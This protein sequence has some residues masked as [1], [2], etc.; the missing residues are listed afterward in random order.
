MKHFSVMAA[1]GIALA[2]VFLFSCQNAGQPGESAALE[3]KESIQDRV[4]HIEKEIFTEIPQVPRWCDRLKLKK[5]RINVGDCELYVE[6][7][8]KGTPLV[9]INGGPG[10]THHYFHPRFG[11]AAKF[12]RVIYYDQRGCGLS[13]YQPGKDGYSVEQAVEDLNAIRKALRIDKWVVLGYSYGGFL[14]QYYAT[15]Y[16]ENLAGLILLGA[17]PGMWVDMK[18]S[19]QYDFLSK[20]ERDRMREIRKELEK[21]SEEKGWSDE[22]SLALLVYNN[23]LNG[24]WKR[25]NYYKPSPEGMARGCLYEWNYDGKN[26][27]RGGI[28]NSQ[29]KIDLTGAFGNFPVPTMILEGRWDLTWNTDKPEILH[30]NHPGSKLV[31]VEDAGHGIYDENPEILFSTLKEFIKGLSKVSPTDVETYKAYVADWDRKLKSSPFYIIRASG[32]GQMS[33]ASLAAAYKKDW[34]DI[35]DDPSLFLKLGFAHYETKNY[36]EALYVFEKMQH[37]AEK[38]QNE[39]RKAVAL[40]WQ[41]HMLDLMGKRAAAVALYKKVADMNNTSGMMHSQYGLEYSYSPY[42]RERMK[43]PFVRVENKEKN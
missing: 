6:E 31:M 35:L 23:F 33:M 40:I 26:N 11:R 28:S 27:F 36:A 38:K 30:K 3:K 17:S 8:G 7:E 37:A 42:A 24:D 1:A 22:K 4:I 19:R 16:P 15:K 25:Q 9:L 12:S 13:D 5:Q 32:Y 14:A 18:P 2:M 41:G 21:I 20:E 39:D 10:G 43:T 34:C 29:N